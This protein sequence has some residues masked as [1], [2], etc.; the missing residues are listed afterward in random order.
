MSNKP[1]SPPQPGSFREFMSSKEAP[2]R[3]TLV[4]LVTVIGVLLVAWDT[5]R[6]ASP[7]TT[8]SKPTAVARP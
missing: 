5:S 2:V 8:I 1:A 7:T 3:V 4:I 6:R